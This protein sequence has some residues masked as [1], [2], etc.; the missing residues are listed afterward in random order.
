[1]AARIQLI[2]QKRETLKSQIEHLERILNEG[3][4]DRSSL[5][6]RMRRLEELFHIF[7]DANDELLVLNPSE[8]HHAEYAIIQDKYYK[9][10]ARVDNLL[11]SANVLNFTETSSDPSIS[12]R[13][14]NTENNGRGRHIKLPEV[15]LPTF[16]GK[17]ESWLSFKNLF[18]SMIDTRD[19][20]TDT[21]KLHYLK[22][23][24][25]GDAAKKVGI[26]TISDINYAKAW[27]LL[28]RSY[29]VKRLLVSRHISLMFELPQIEE[30]S[31]SGF[32]KLADEMQ[33]HVAS[34][35]ALGVSVTAETAIHILESRLPTTTL[36][37]WENSLERE[38]LPTLDKMYEFLYRLAVCASRR[39][40]IRSAELDTTSGNIP[41]KK[42][43]LQYPNKSFMTNTTR[44][45]T[46]CSK[47]VHP[48]YKCGIF[49]EITIPDRIEAVKKAHLCFNC[50]RSHRG[51]P[52]R[53]SGCT[54][55]Q[56]RHNTLIHRSEIE[57][58]KTKPDETKNQA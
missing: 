33:Q 11:I 15:K 54:I 22:A 19:D 47:E 20:L 29:E 44:N 13:Q 30:E 17:Y 43:R 24:L 53:S 26:F 40:R 27:E 50:L 34:L 28:E 39:D 49:R 36:K 45:C 1:M 35:S 2:K 21:D 4:T 18:H 56:K 38:E 37:E 10:A 9:L 8:S 52:C 51:K 58:V 7:E 31:T 48:L 12:S 14:S 42:K 23:A 5:R 6:L 25:I 46:V 57:T 32:S 41:T 16:D 3:K 55:C